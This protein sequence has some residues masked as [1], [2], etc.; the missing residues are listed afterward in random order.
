M[1]FPTTI[2]TTIQAAGEHDR[3][4]LER[5][6][7]RYRQPVLRFVRRKGFNG[8]DAEDV[9]QDVF[10]RVLAGDVLSRADSSRGKFRSLLLA[11]TQHVILDR[12]RKKSPVATGVIEVEVGDPEPEFDREWILTLAER[13]FA[14]LRESGSPYY[15][16]LRDH[17]EGKRHTRNKLWI[18]RQKLI[19]L[20]RREVAFT[21]SSRGEVEEELVYLSR[22]LR[23][24][25]SARNDQE[26]PGD[27]KTMRH[28]SGRTDP[29]SGGGNAT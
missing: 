4:A 29:D 7:A 11:V 8:H 1:S 26:T 15:R 10:V 16:V 17:L 24:A 19:A 18:A 3:E 5:F 25:S 23:P 21:C 9:C 12:W 14:Q 6:A 2:W 20:I 22:Y 13:A 27:R 28:A